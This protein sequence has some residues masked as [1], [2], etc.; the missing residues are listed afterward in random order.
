MAHVKLEIKAPDRTRH[1]NAKIAI[2]AFELS[3]SLREKWLAADYVA[4]R[5]AM[6]S[7]I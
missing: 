3:P 5:T 4:N 1:E 2:N 7:S 6:K